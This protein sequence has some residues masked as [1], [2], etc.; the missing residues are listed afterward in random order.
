MKKH[1]T[2][3]VPKVKAKVSVR[4][5]LRYVAVAGAFAMGVF[6]VAVLYNMLG[7]SKE[8]RANNRVNGM[9]T[10]AEFKFRKQVMINTPAMEHNES[11]YKFPIMISVSD[12]DLRSAGHGGK[13]LSEQGN[14]LRF[15]KGDGVSLLDYEIESY[16]PVNGNLVAW[17]KIDTLNQYTKPVFLYFNNQFAANESSQ[18][19][20]NKTYKGVWHLRGSLSHKTPWSN[21][22]SQMPGNKS[23]KDVYV[24]AEK[25]ASQFPCLNT[26]EDV[27]ITGDLTVSAW[28]RLDD[29]KEQTILSNQSGFNGGYRL[30]INKDRKVEFE[31]RNENSVPATL[32]GETNGTVLEKGVWYYVSAV[33]S[34]SGDSLATYIN[35]KYDRG[36]KTDISL[37]GS[38]DPLQIGREPNRKIYYFGGL[39]DEVHVANV[40][41]SAAWIQ[42]EFANQS[43]PK[44]FLKIGNTEAIEQQI[45]LTLLTFDAEPKGNT[46]ELKWLTVNEVEN[47]SFTIERS[48]DGV[49]Y[50]KIGTKPGA[51]NSNEVLSYRFVDG[52]PL[53]GTNYYRVKLTSSS[54]AEEY[55]MVTPVNVEAESEG[56]VRIN[57]AQPNPFSN[58][59]EVSFFVPKDGQTS[60]KLLNL[61]GETIHEEAMDCQKNNA[62][63]FKYKDQNQLKPGVY[64]FQVAQDA[65]RKQVKLIKRL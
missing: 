12:P 49:S 59:F 10:L 61:K 63:V 29:K 16:D 2:R 19:A 65:D 6:S 55:S 44:G 39:I 34:D 42:T 27:D 17:V 52:K 9:E 37:A 36:M 22:V 60:V 25:N 57:M 13:V 47:E 50:E 24:A 54:G 58:E 31:I 53:I 35:G 4:H 48:T 46:V 51:G 56:T 45:S 7:N 40:V 38:S 32:K 5:R 14:D 64:F 20:W 23:D 15:T 3:L 8:S 18:N 62:Q 28:V 26:P 43:N 33:Y 41:R 21:Q 1:S 11:L 30:S